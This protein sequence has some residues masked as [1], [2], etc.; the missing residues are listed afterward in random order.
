M[1]TSCQLWTAPAPTPAIF[2]V[3]ASAS[4]VHARTAHHDTSSVDYLASSPV[5]D[6]E[7]IQWITRRLRSHHRWAKA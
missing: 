6:V 4:L 5:C 1:P 7:L 3:H 2:R